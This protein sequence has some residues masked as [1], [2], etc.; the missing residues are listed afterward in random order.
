MKGL[1]ERNEDYVTK[2]NMLHY[3]AYIENDTLKIDP[4]DWRVSENAPGY[5]DDYVVLYAFTADSTYKEMHIK[6]PEGM[7]VKILEE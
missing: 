2:Y 7:L 5:E 6:I 4:G 1:Q 3:R